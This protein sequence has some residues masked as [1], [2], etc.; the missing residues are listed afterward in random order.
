MFQ[1]LQLFFILNLEY[2]NLKFVLYFVFPIFYCNYA[3]STF[4]LHGKKSFN[5]G[6]RESAAQ[7][8]FG[9]DEY[10]VSGNGKRI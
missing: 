9:N 10:S 3:L 8:N 6:F 4:Y 5:L 1:F 2:L 7:K